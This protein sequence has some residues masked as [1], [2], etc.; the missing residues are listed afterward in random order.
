MEAEPPKT[1]DQHDTTAGRWALPQDRSR[2]KR[3]MEQFGTVWKLL[4][5]LFLTV[6]IGQRLVYTEGTRLLGSQRGMTSPQFL[7]FFEAGNF[8]LVF[9]LTWL[10][11]LAEKTPF[12]EYGLPLKQAFKGN[13]SVGFLLGLA[14]ASV[15]VG[16]VAIF[17][18]YSFGALAEHGADILKWGLLELVGFIFVGLYEEFLF[19]GYLQHSLSKLVGFWP[20]G[21]VLSVGFGAV[22]LSNQGEDWVGAASIVVVG[23]LFVFTL[24][25]TGNLWYAV[26][27]HAGFDWAESFLY[28][29]PDSGELIFGHLSDS[30]L[31]G[32]KWLTGGSVG[33]EGSVFCFVTM[34]LQFLV[35]MWLFPAKKSER[36]AEAAAIGG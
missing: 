27:L 15:L 6:G 1:G 36:V 4:L 23:L 24:K 34:G 2:P 22:H 7:L 10:L 8:A 5:F 30:E 13:F 16:L 35:V 28:S 14:E 33:P 19:R 21:I 11:S 20:A 31:H 29:V 26:G 32:P 12:G 9:G 25:R 3:R 17:G 18:G